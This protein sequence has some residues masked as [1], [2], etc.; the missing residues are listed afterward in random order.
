MGLTH[1]NYRCTY[2]MVCMTYEFHLQ[3]MKR[4]VDLY[5]AQELQI[6]PSCILSV[7]TDSSLK[8]KIRLSHPIPLSGIDSN[9][10]KI[11]VH[12]FL[13]TE[14]TSDKSGII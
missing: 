8:P 11:Y 5:G 4:D 12:R 14:D 10:R 7:W 3:L 9:T 13:E 1:S 6:P 2:D